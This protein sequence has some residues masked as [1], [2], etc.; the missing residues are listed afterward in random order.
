MSKAIKTL[1]VGLAAA[2]IAVPLAQ[3][4]VGRPTDVGRPADV[5]RPNDRGRMNPWA[6]RDAIIRGHVQHARPTNV[7]RLLPWASRGVAAY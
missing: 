5:G 1:V 4:D 6:W 3:A 2:A 7:K